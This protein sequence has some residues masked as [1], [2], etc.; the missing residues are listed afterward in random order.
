[1]VDVSTIIVSYNT[2]HLLGEAVGKLQTASQGLSV[3]C[4]FVDNASSDQSA[5][6][7]QQH[8]P[9]DVL[10]ENTHNVG[11][12]RANNQALAHAHG[13]YVLLL[14]TDA[15]VSPD[16]LQKTVAYM[17]Q[18]PR[19]G[20]LGVRLEG[21][22]GG[23]QPCARFFPTPWNLFVQRTGLNKLFPSTQLVDDMDWD[24]ASVREC[25]WVVGCY[26]LVRKEV[27]DQVGLFD[28]RYFL[29]FEEVD[30]C[31]AAKKAGWKVVFYPH[32]TV[33]HLGGESAKSSGAITK[34]GKQLSALQVESEILYMRKNHGLHGLL[35]DI[36]LSLLAD[37]V[38]TAKH[39]LRPSRWHQLSS[40]TKHAQLF[41][42]LCIKT[43][44]GTK[45]T[46]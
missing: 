18:N 38:Q 30:H 45:P 14:N 19:C 27:I 1:M 8:F 6:Y 31:F 11:F 43:R 41:L 22:D 37:A 17:D 2:A 44:L 21:A 9:H 12:G 5:A 13:R 15:F 26:Y 39:L 20:I 36:G 28:P 4:I 34:S 46:R 35:L 40:G 29:Y 23:L 25:D 33:V 3:E 10:I 16:T 42:Q 7:I 32:T 24:H